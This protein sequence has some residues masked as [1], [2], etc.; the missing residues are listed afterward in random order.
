MAD[1]QCHEN[2]LNIKRLVASLYRNYINICTGL[3][4]FCEMCLAALWDEK[5]LIQVEFII[6]RVAT[7]LPLSIDLWQQKY[8]YLNCGM[9]RGIAKSC[10]PFDLFHSQ[11]NSS[12]YKTQC[13][14]AIH[15]DEFYEWA[16]CFLLHY[17]YLL[18][19][20][21]PLFWST[22]CCRAELQSVANGLVW[23]VMNCKRTELDEYLYNKWFIHSVKADVFLLG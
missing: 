21:G 11:K 23:L 2:R 9:C 22:V 19:L 15:K 20:R 5:K 13:F 14:V 6:F 7:F 12:H 3:D 18:F 16:V 10:D 17:F 4:I 8:K 1:G